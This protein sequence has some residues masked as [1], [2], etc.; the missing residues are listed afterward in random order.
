L[1]KALKGI[2]STDFLTRATIGTSMA[3]MHNTPGQTKLAQSN[4]GMQLDAVPATRALR[5]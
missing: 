1:E 4:K 5:R 2:H 3:S